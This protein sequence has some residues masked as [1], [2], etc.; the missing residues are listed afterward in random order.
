MK[1]HGKFSKHEKHDY[2]DEE[3]VSIYRKFKVESL[4]LTLWRTRLATACGPAVRQT[5][6]QIVASPLS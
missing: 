4:N 6:K 1:K 3:G 5:D 2:E